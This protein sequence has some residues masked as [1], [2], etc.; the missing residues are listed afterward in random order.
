MHFWYFFFY[1]NFAGPPNLLTPLSL[2]SRKSTEPNTFVTMGYT[3]HSMG[4]CDR[5]QGAQVLLRTGAYARQ[6]EFLPSTCCTCPVYNRPG[7]QPLTLHHIQTLST[8]PPT[9]LHTH[10]PQS[11]LGCLPSC[12]YK[13]LGP[14]RFH[15]LQL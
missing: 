13:D 7:H 5:V 11:Q 4:Q 12:S 3:R 6:P 14:K 2:F 10:K 15:L 8:L 9:T 1:H